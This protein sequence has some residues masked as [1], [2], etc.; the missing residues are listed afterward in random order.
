MYIDHL[1]LLTYPISQYQFSL[2]KHNRAI[3]TE[4]YK[5]SC[6]LRICEQSTATCLLLGQVKPHMYNI[7]ALASGPHTQTAV[8]CCVPC[9]W[10][11]LNYCGEQSVGK[12][13]IESRL[14]GFWLRSDYTSGK[15]FAWSTNSKMVN[16]KQV[17]WLL[18]L[19]TD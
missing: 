7:C 17:A 9:V 10:S 6:M 5:I 15:S 12:W 18:W 4:E 2:S 19:R 3:V 14:L 8:H 1:H 16:V 13:L 11:K